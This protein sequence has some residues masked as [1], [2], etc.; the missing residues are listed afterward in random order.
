MISI[1][2]A[3]IWS[4]IVMYIMALCAFNREIDR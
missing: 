1:A 3:L 4:I 2:M